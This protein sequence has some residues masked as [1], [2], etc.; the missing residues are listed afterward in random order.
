[1]L[2]FFYRLRR[3]GGVVLFAV[4]AIMTVLIAMATTAYFAAR[5][6]YQTVV[7]NYDF[8]Q[9]YVSTTSLSDM[10]IGALTQSTSRPDAKG[11]TQS[12]PG[13]DVLL[14]DY[15]GLKQ[16]VIS[17]KDAALTKVE[18]GMSCEDAVKAVT[19]LEGYSSNIY[20]SKGGTQNQILT[21]AAAE[22]VEA[23]IVDG[24]KVSIKLEKMVPETD[25]SGLKT[26]RYEY[27]FTITT[28][29]YYR[30]NVVSVQ[31]SMW[32]VSGKSAG[33]GPSFDSFFKSTGGNTKAKGDRAVVIGT[34]KI[35][36]NAYFENTYTIFT[37]LSG[38]DNI[39]LGGVTATGSVYF[40]RQCS[41][42][43]PRPGYV[44]GTD[45]TE[46]AMANA[47]HDWFINGNLGLISDNS[48]TID[49][50][51]NNMYINGDLIIANQDKGITAHNVYVTGNIYLTNGSAKITL[52]DTNGN[53]VAPGSPGAGKL[54]CGGNIYCSDPATT[55][56]NKIKDSWT[57]KYGSTWTTVEDEYKAIKNMTT[58]A[59]KEVGGNAVMSGISTGNYSGITGRISNSNTTLYCKGSISSNFAGKLTSK[60][61]YDPK[62]TSVT[63]STLTATADGK[64][65]E[66]KEST[67]TV[68]KLFDMDTGLT[69]TQDWDAYTAKQATLDNKLTIDIKNAPKS[70][71][72]PNYD[73]GKGEWSDGSKGDTFEK[74]FT[75][76]DGTTGY[77][78]KA[79]TGA[80]EYKFYSSKDTAKKNPA[81]V[82]K[83]DADNSATVYIPYTS[84]GYALT[85]LNPNEITN[86]SNGGNNPTQINI[87]TVKDKTMPIVL[88]GNMKDGSNTPEDD[89]G[90]NAFSWSGA[91]GNKA[92]GTTGVLAVQ[93]VTTTTGSTKDA[94]GDN[95]YTVA[96]ADGNAIFEMG[97]IDKATREYIAYDPKNDAKTDTVTF[98]IG[99]RTVMGTKAQLDEIIGKTV[100]D[101]NGN[102]DK[103]A[104][105]SNVNKLYDS[106]K[107]NGSDVDPKFENRLMIVSSK[108]TNSMNTGVGGTVDASKTRAGIISDT[109]Q[110]DLICG[111]IYAPNAMYGNAADNQNVP[112][113][114]GLIVSEYVTGMATYK[115]A[116]PDPS[117]IESMLSGLNKP[118]GGGG[119]TPLEGYWYLEGANVG[120]NF[121]G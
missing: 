39:F 62:S 115:Y 94:F 56:L 73:S 8:S 111:Y 3:R 22:P 105:E 41:T 10:I 2:K 101:R 35:S 76:D 106:T 112:I 71:E 66:Y 7:S 118:G 86:L 48:G 104:K 75:C 78:V 58:N 4:I 67:M 80:V 82:S 52:T 93:L 70:W 30:N 15:T 32:N 60:G 77:I 74:S 42:K 69:K 108:N 64:S 44:W 57:E 79:K 107:A 12:S 31:D 96:S 46:K 85:W 91:S 26:G 34:E 29:G 99:E 13:A 116:E 61:S 1:M 20:G 65:Y 119:G 37:E 114:G 102:K 98:R 33:K 121:V 19:P 110:H 11:T 59:A 92:A 6:S 97:N 9:L 100:A 17:V 51:G 54:Y 40:T 36:D 89:N 24:V 27:Y 16:A 87:G 28:T 83:S 5:S 43:I 14:N 25:I 117:I 68:D 49:L 72:L 38:G 55:N 45:G 109:N 23:G 63:V 21:A 90:Y 84:D 18:G 95:T 88:C 120:R 53:V 103:C 50:K 113:F 81:I 47:R